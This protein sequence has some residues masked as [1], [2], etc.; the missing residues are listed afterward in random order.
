MSQS[1]A[2]SDIYESQAR[3]GRTPSVLASILSQWWIAFAA[4]S[5]FVVGGHLLIKVG[6]NNLTALPATATVLARVLHPVLNPIVLAG[7]AIYVMG[8]ICW[9]RAVSLKEISFLY[10]L[11]SVNFVLITAVSMLM[12]NEELSLRRNGGIALVMA[13]MLLMN[14]RSKATQS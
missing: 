10:P 11:S 7:L 4:S 3:V 1:L 9:M 13:G 12:L 2:N 5:I 8:T 6:L 14:K